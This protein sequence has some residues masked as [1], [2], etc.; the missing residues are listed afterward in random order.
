MKS[1]RII[2][3][4]NFGFTNNA[5]DTVLFSVDTKDGDV[6]TCEVSGLVTPE[7][8]WIDSK[9]ARRIAAQLIKAADYLDQG[10]KK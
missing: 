2:K 3:P 5:G 8:V 7:R 9:L 6:I 10:P 4:R 1:K